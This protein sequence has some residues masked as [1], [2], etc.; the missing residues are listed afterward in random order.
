MEDFSMNHRLAIRAVKYVCV[1][2]LLAVA[3]TSFSATVYPIHFSSGT[4]TVENA[5]SPGNT[6][7]I[8]IQP[9]FSN[10]SISNPPQAYTAQLVG[11]NVAYG[12]AVNMPW[13]YTGK[14]PLL[15]AGAPVFTSNIL[16]GKPS[17]SPDITCGL[18]VSIYPSAHSSQPDYVVGPPY[19]AAQVP[20]CT[21]Y[22]ASLVGKGNVSIAMTGMN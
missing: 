5:Y 12:A 2:I 3:L 11:K 16:I 22:K 4:V 14:N 7:A 20:I 1:P 17:T 21:H 18:S 15:S 9:Q 13:T 8:S 19:N 10:A 6:M